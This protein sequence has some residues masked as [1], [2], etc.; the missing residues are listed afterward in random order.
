MHVEQQSCMKTCQLRLLTYQEQQECLVVAMPNTVVDPR[1][2]VILHMHTHM[3]MH[4][5][6]QASVTQLCRQ[7]GLFECSGCCKAGPCNT[8][9]V[10]AITD[11]M[12]WLQLPDG[13]TFSSRS[14][15]STTCRC[16]QCTQAASLRLSCQSHPTAHSPLAR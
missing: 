15:V 7:H 12:I 14:V 10:Y 16:S 3:Y 9:H 8:K 4:D 13:T 6:Q 2:V 11:F 5:C 1:A